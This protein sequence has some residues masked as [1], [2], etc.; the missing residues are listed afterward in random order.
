VVRLPALRIGRLYPQ[1]TFLVFISVRGWVDP[2]GHSAAGRIMSMKNSNNTIGNQTRDLPAQCLNQL[3]H[4]VPHQKWVPGV[5]PG[6]KGGRCVGLTNLEYSCADWYW[7]LGASVFW[8]PEGLS[9]PVM[10]LLYLLRISTKHTKLIFIHG[11]PASFS[12]SVSFL[13]QLDTLSFLYNPCLS[14]H[15][16]D[17]SVH[18]QEDLML[19][20]TSSFWR[21]SLGRWSVLGGRWC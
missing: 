6:G 9:S 17:Q 21:R 7:N 14:L 8:N 1:E 2:Q 10:G 5:F 20:Y 15:V 12:N 16:S 3:R 18:H 13:Y 19:N 11:W 4:R